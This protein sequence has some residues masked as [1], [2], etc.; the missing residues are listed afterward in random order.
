MNTSRLLL[1]KLFRRNLVSSSRYS[2][3]VATV[4]IS[5]QPSIRT[6]V[7]ETLEDFPSYFTPTFNFAAYM[8]KSET[9]K[10]FFDLG[11]DL[12]KIEKKG[13]LAQ[14]V[15]KLDFEKDVKNH[16]LFLHDLGIPAENYGR[17]I[18]K[19]PLIFKESID[20]LQT[21]VYYM[22]SKKFSMEKIRDIVVRNPFWLNFSTK[23]ID[24]RLGWFMKN[25]K[26]SPD[27]LRY[28]T[29]KQPKLITFSIELI[30][31]ANFTIKEE[32]GFERE[33]FKELL[34]AKP[35]LWMIRK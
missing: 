2:S 19:N 15:L 8:N 27:E 7:E 22:R 26:L 18:T 14:F 10:K 31:V 28:L 23:R 21:R 17:F 35:L 3:T 24:R 9:L 16:L 4:E 20:D 30:R 32:M 29:C 34:L 5:N 25:F 12:S 11:V 6:P 33:Q 13:G 1:V